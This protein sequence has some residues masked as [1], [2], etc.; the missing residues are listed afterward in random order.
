MDEAKARSLQFKQNILHGR[1]VPKH[2]NTTCSFLGCTLAQLEV[3]MQ[4]SNPGTQIQ[5]A[6]VPS[7][8]LTTSSLSA[9]QPIDLRQGTGV[10]RIWHRHRSFLIITFPSFS[11]AS[12]DLT[13]KAK[14]S[15]PSHFRP[16]TIMSNHGDYCMTTRPGRR[17]GEHND[18][19][20]RQPEVLPGHGWDNAHKKGVLGA[21]TLWVLKTG[22]P[23]MVPRQYVFHGTGVWKKKKN[24]GRDSKSSLW[25]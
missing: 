10:H 4:E 20:E 1:E 13:L 8:S 21:Y 17:G 16:S 3:E 23:F 15:S 24:R 2:L 11:I 6:G 12:P 19:K 5:T 9:T 18:Q 22:S 25:L 7:I 14:V